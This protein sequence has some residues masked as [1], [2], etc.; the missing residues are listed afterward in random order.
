M[1]NPYEAMR[2]K[3]SRFNDWERRMESRLSSDERLNRFLLLY[4]LG[5]ASDPGVIRRRHEE[6]LQAL[7]AAGKRLKGQAG[8][9]H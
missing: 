6:H 7:I 4:D 2:D 9:P 1:P 3:L 5:R 8:E